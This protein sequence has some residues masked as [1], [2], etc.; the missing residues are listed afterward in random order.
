MG[1]I[2][3]AKI[4]ETVDMINRADAIMLGATGKLAE[5]EKKFK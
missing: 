5:L 3:E 1:Q 2:T 4:Q